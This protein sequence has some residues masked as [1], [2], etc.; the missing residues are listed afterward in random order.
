MGVIP[1]P[2]VSFGLDLFGK[3][4]VKRLSQAYECA[5]RAYF[6][7]VSIGVPLKSWRRPEISSLNALLDM[8][9]FDLSKQN[10]QDGENTHPVLI[11]EVPNSNNIVVDNLYTIFQCVSSEFVGNPEVSPISFRSERPCWI[12]FNYGWETYFTHCFAQSYGTVS[13]TQPNSRNEVTHSIA[14]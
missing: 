4:L 12:D 8:Y 14:A 3:I 5:C 1:A 10:S 11:G 6:E 9:W 7:E 2:G 13:E